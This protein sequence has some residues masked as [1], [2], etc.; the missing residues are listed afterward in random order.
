MLRD[1]GQDRGR[2]TPIAIR[3][4]KNTAQLTEVEHITQAFPLLSRAWVY[5][6]RMLSR[7][8]LYCNQ[9]ELQLECRE[10]ITCE[11]TNR[12]IPPH[13]HPRTEAGKSMLSVKRQYANAL[14]KHGIRG[15][16]SPSELSQHWQWVVMQYS[17]LQLTYPSDILP[18]LSGCAKDIGQRTGDTYLA[19]IWRNS[20][21]EGL[22]WTLN[23][24]ITHPRP[25]TP[26]APRGSNGRGFR[27]F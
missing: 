22:L 15:H 12:F 16:Y 3:D 19:G 11:C 2:T 24:P 26:R 7:R 27:A 4:C 9:S 5:Q 1:Y 8:V 14:K 23:P 18:A 10:G 6:E 13:P 25:T 20:L 21:A 17:R